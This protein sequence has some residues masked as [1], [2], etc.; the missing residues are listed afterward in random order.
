MQT[1]RELDGVS[2]ETIN[3]DLTG[4][5]DLTAAQQLPEN[6]GICFIGTK[7]AG[8]FNLPEKEAL[9]L[10]GAA[11]PNGLPNSDV[12]RPWVNGEALYNVPQHNGLWML[13]SMALDDFEL[14]ELAVLRV[15]NR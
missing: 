5:L 12:L 9:A 2:V 15:W 13:A 8:D 3:A 1:A 11:N 10:L 4:D 6:A 7:K 14:Y